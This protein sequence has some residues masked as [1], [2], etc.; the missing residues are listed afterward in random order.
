[1]HERLGEVGTYCRRPDL[2]VETVLFDQICEVLTPDALRLIGPFT[3]KSAPHL[4]GRLK[5][6]PVSVHP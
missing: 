3:K 4:A 2:A 5:T 6:A 1:M